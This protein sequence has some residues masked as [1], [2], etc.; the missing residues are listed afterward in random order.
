MPD[1]P[2]LLFLSCAFSVCLVSLARASECDRHCDGDISCSLDV[3]AC[4]TEQ[5]RPRDS[6]ELLKPLFTAH[7]GDTGLATALSGAYLADGNSFWALRTLMIAHEIVPNDCLVRSWIAW[8][9]ITQ[10]D[11]DL[12]REKLAEPGCP[13]APAEVSR[14]RLLEGF[15]A[16]SEEDAESAKRALDE[17]DEAGTVFSSDKALWSYLDEF[18]DPNR[19]DAL[20]WSVELSGGYTS[21]ARAGSPTDPDIEG[22]PSAL[23]RADIYV[24]FAP[25]LPWLVRP[26]VDGGIKLHGITDPG[27][28]NLSYMELSVRPGVVVGK[29]SLTVFVGYKPDLLL[30]AQEG[31]RIFY[32]GHRAEIEVE[33]SR[34]TL[35]TG[36]GRRIFAEGGRTR[37]E[38]DGGLGTWFTPGQRTRLL[39]ALSGRAQDAT[40]DSYDLLGASAL[41]VGRVA[42]GAGIDLRI[43]A[44]LG[45]D[46]YLNSGGERGILAHGIDDERRDWTAKLT[47]GLWGP[48]WSGVR[49]GL[50]YEFATR[51]SNAQTESQDYSYMEHRVLAKLKWQAGF[52]PRTPSI[53]ES[54]EPMP[55][56]YGVG[57]AK[58]GGG[59]EE[60][61]QDLMRQDEAARRGSSCVD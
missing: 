47:G 60:R 13:R 21:N 4:Y 26:A 10:G 51:S 32:E 19:P 22:A 29:D 34:L 50:G 14:W 25:P 40:G 24:R 2:K 54:V 61:I 39:F 5:G 37:L 23:G 46:S 31:K 9:H 7:P 53:E 27:S 42:L 28:R 11:F 20:E 56:D 18:Y 52:D 38:L 55:L 3:A 48:S 12:A 1:M 8:V 16:K 44:I 17:V 49:L 33:F 41:G 15:M 36:G 59:D 45:Y 30:L 35:F 6:I 57:P 43:S 58:K